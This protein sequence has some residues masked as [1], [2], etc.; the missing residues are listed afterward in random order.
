[1][2]LGSWYWMSCYIICLSLGRL[3]SCEQQN[4]HGFHHCLICQKYESWTF[5]AHM[6]RSWQANHW[7]FMVSSLA[8]AQVFYQPFL[9]WKESLSFLLTGN[10]SWKHESTK[11]HFYNKKPTTVN[12]LICNHSTTLPGQYQHQTPNKTPKSCDVMCPWDPQTTSAKEVRKS[13]VRETR[14]EGV[15]KTLKLYVL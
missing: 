10:H 12:L 11:S 5:L 9:E 7:L 2:G 3:T 14:A 4:Q 13:P 1:M 8:F 6:H 15:R